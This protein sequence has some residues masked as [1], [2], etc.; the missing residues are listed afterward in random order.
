[1]PTADDLARFI[2]GCRRRRHGRNRWQHAVRAAAHRTIRHLDDEPT[3][4]T[5]RSRP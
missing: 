2:A 4:D 5:T 1:M 3:D